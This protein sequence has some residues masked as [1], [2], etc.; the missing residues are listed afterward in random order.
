VPRQLD[1]DIPRLVGSHSVKVWAETSE[2]ARAT[3]V[4]SL[5]SILDVVYVCCAGCVS[6]LRESKTGI[7]GLLRRQR[8]HGALKRVCIRQ[9][10][11][12]VKRET[13]RS[14]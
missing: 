11:T 6:V 9:M 14:D 4:R 2:A 12:L 1:E 13:G 5:E 3:E 7:G 10:R 8:G